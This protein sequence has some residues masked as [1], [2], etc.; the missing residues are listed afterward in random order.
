MIILSSFSVVVVFVVGYCCCDVHWAQWLKC[1]KHNMIFQ[2]IDLCC[3]AGSKQESRDESM[4]YGNGCRMS[5]Q[6]VSSVPHT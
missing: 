5:P 1:H 6:Q 3:Y 4:V 2:R